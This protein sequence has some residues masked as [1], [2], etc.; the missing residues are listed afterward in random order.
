MNTSDDKEKNIINKIKTFFS[1][2]FKKKKDSQNDDSID[3]YSNNYYDNDSSYYSNNYNNN[4]N[5]S[6]NYHGND[7][8]NYSNNYYG[9]KEFNYS[10]EKKDN[11]N[12]FYNNPKTNYYN[13]SN[14]YYENSNSSSSN[15]A[16]DNFY[17]T[18]STKKEYEIKENDNEKEGNSRNKKIYIIIALALVLT[19]LIIILLITMF[20]KNSPDINLLVTNINLKVG[21]NKYISYE[22]VN[23][24]DVI[25]VSFRSSDT[26]V[27][28]VDANGNV[29][30]VGGG[31]ATIYLEYKSGIRTKEKTCDVTVEGA[32]NSNPTN[33][34]NNQ[35]NTTKKNNNSTNPVIKTPPTLTLSL[36]NNSWS[37][38]NVIVRA[39]ASSNSGGSVRL[40]YAVNCSKN[41][42]YTN[43]TGSIVINM[44]GTNM[45]T[46]VA[47]DTLNNT[48]TEKSVFVK[49]DKTSPTISLINNQGTFT[50]NTS[51]EICATCTDR[52]SGCK[53]DKVCQIYTSSA[54]NQT[55]KGEDNA[56]NVGTSQAFN[57]VINGSGTNNSGNN[58]NN[59]TTTPIVA[60]PS[61]SLN[62][63]GNGI[64]TATTS[65]AT[66]YSFD[67]SFKTNDK[68]YQIPQVSKKLENGQSADEIKNV[69]YYVKNGNLTSSCSITVKVSCTCKYMYANQ[70]YQNRETKIVSSD[71]ECQNY[72]GNVMVSGSKW[73]YIHTNP[74]YSC[75]FTKR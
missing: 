20:G 28:T 40:K 57:V 34:S 43:T 55:L 70:C 44:E 72:G 62:V 46:V 56:G 8:Q 32:N 5:Y 29:L 14:N 11:S 7:N 51:I 37:N 54:S 71:R 52:E 9:N 53:K 45:V 27:A 2:K 50:S 47:E 26:S 67:S 21:E 73:C 66:S 12:N 33:T 38:Q 1:S 6:G 64:V 15:N 60:M 22:M 48:E 36:S 23:S 75:T 35:N 16:F 31:K 65:N 58:N 3:L 10:E 41:C 69:S 49:I 13:S 42:S 30:G 25:E 74:G 61:C 4:Q 24:Q 59:S 63:S 39:N 68:T 18:S 19:I 17:S